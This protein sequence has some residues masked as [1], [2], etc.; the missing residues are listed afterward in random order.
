M[1]LTAMPTS[2]YDITPRWFGMFRQAIHIDADTDT[3]D[4]R[5]PLRLRRRRVIDD[6][7]AHSFS[8]FADQFLNSPYLDENLEESSGDLDLGLGFD[9]DDADEDNQS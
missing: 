8:R 9:G 6:L 4:W 1:N 7:L 5:G 3:V 2:Y